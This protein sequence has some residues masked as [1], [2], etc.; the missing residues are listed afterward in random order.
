MV[1]KHVTKFCK[2]L[3]NSAIEVPLGMRKFILKKRE[4]GTELTFAKTYGTVIGDMEKI[5]Q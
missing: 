2:G 3:A 5:G 4:D 1:S